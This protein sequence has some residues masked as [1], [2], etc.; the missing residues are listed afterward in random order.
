MGALRI[1]TLGDSVTKGVRPGVEEPQTFS[2]LLEGGLRAR[3]M[4]AEVINRGIGGE[5]T[6]GGLARLDEILALVPRIVTVMYGINDSTAA[7]GG[8]TPPVPIALFRRNLEEILVRLCSIGVRPLLLTANP[9]SAF[10]V[11]KDYYADFPP[12]SDRGINCL[13]H[14]HV[15]AMRQVGEALAVPVLDVFAVFMAKAGPAGDLSSLLT[16]GM[17]PNPAGHALIAELLLAW[18]GWTACAS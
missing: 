10:G 4:Q 12:Y 13:L 17:H 3:G 1:V 8:E 6:S 9:L 2:S 14:P 5:T 16:D 7:P 15:A 18:K 11:T